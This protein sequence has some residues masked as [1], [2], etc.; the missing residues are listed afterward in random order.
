MRENMKQSS[1]C[2][3]VVGLLVPLTAGLFFDSATAN[4][5][6]Y[7]PYI[8]IKSDGSIEPETE[9]IEQHGSTYTL[10]GDISGKYAVIIQCSNIV[11]DGAGYSVN[12]S[13][14]YD[15]YSNI[16]L[17]LENVKNVTVKNIS[18]IRFLG[19]AGILCSNCSECLLYNTNT[20]WI[21][22]LSDSHF[23]TVS[24]CYISDT[25]GLGV[26]NQV[27]QSIIE[28]L[29]LSN[30]S[31][32]SK[33]NITDILIS[34]GCHSNTIYGNNF[35]GQKNFIATTEKNFWNNGSMGNYWSDYSGN[36][37]YFINNNNVD[38]YPLTAPVS[39]IQ[40]QIRCLL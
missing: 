10:T 31:Y 19:Y 40:H 32:V 30:D 35:L 38:H 13:S 4:P 16:G 21:L 12:G 14:V 9:L 11:F 18:I 8:T 22:D 23:V 28:T 26:N 37:P 3:L 17:S 36:G 27:T 5:S 2:I 25:F 6:V 29:K 34:T 1:V 33:N 24:H 15:A 7:L 39:I 20:T